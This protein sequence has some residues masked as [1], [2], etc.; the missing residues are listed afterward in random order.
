MTSNRSFPADDYDVFCI[1]LKINEYNALRAEI[2][3]HFQNRNT[4]LTLGVTLLGITL[5]SLSQNK[6]TKIINSLYDFLCV[7]IF[8]PVICNFVISFWLIFTV[9]IA[10]IGHYIGEYVEEYI[11]KLI[12]EKQPVPVNEDNSMTNKYP[13][14]WENFIRRRG[15][16]GKNL[17]FKP[18]EFW[19]ASSILAIFQTISIAALIIAFNVSGTVDFW[20]PMKPLILGVGVSIVIVSSLIEIYLLDKVNEHFKDSVYLIKLLNAVP[21]V[22]R[23]LNRGEKDDYLVK[24]YKKYL[25]MIENSD[26]LNSQPPDH[27]RVIDRKKLRDFVVLGTGKRMSEIQQSYLSTPCNN[28]N[29][30]YLNFSEKETN[31][32]PVR[33]RTL[34]PANSLL[35]AIQYLRQNE[36]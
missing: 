11:S 20:I 13:L 32:D 5:A 14:Y 7:S 17:S 21:R 36:P 24:L 23:L 10:R 1:H 30:Y 34:F 33:I 25:D 26:N 29:N 15:E 31:G 19:Q 27:N 9:K 35:S 3:S 16:G 12:K 22:W 6:D 8:I 4:L 28:D 18:Y 2:L